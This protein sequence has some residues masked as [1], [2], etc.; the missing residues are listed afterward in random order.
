ME[1]T[2]SLVNRLTAVASESSY[3]DDAF[4]GSDPAE[5]LAFLSFNP[6]TTNEI[7]PDAGMRATHSGRSHDVFQ[8]GAS[9][10]WEI[11]LTGIVDPNGTPALPVTPLLLAS[12]WAQQAIVGPPPSYEHNLVTG[13]NMTK[14]PSCTFVE[15]LIEHDGENARKVVYTGM[16]GNST[17]TLEMGQPVRLSGEFT[18]KFASFPSSATP[19]PA[20]PAVYS[21][22]ENRFIMV[23][24]ELTADAVSYPVESVNFS[25]NWQVRE[26]RDGTTADTTLSYVHLERSPGDR[27]TGSMTLKGRSAALNTLLPAIEAGTAFE[28]VVSLENSNGDTLTITAPSMQFGSFGRGGDGAMTFD[29]PIHCNGTDAGENEL[30]LNFGRSA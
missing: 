7:V 28:L 10:S 15:Y 19:K 4:V 20:T 12:N 16:R 27:V 23:G 30:T 24:A 22:E 29:V 3:G 17:L 8:G 18:G 2:L 9:V 14:V 13:D 5:F 26:D 6:T 11:A 21:G 1:G 25:T